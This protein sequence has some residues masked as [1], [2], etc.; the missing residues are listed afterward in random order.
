MQANQNDDKA[1][2]LYAFTCTVLATNV[3]GK[4][5]EKLDFATKVYLPS[6]TNTKWLL[7]TLHLIQCAGFISILVF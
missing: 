5:K 1:S 6:Y 7:A 2:A 4:F 3:L